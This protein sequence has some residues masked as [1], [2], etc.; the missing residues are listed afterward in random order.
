MTASSE[1]ASFLRV[2]RQHFERYPLMQLED[3]YKLVH[4]AHFGPGHMVPDAA[5]AAAGLMNEAKDLGDGPVEPMFD[6]I[7]PNG[8]V[9][10]VHL[11]PYLAYGGSLD[12]LAGSF[13]RTA[14]SFRGS[15]D[16]LMECWGLVVALATEGLIPFSREEATR[17]WQ[18]VQTNR[19]PAVHHSP[20]F[21][22]AY[23]PAYR[24]IAK[25]FWP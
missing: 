16:E 22:Q 18:I 23:H 11:R 25:E 5:V 19:F 10:R 6:P 7:T 8:S 1:K 20:T 9:V 14:N 12:Q 3:F 4:Q 15:G 17:V 13:I 21:Q 24:V 2:F